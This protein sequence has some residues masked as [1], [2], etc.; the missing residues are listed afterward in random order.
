MRG[1]VTCHYS[2]LKWCET[3]KV[4]GVRPWWWSASCRKEF[5]HYGGYVVGKACRSETRRSGLHHDQLRQSSELP[6]DQSQTNDRSSSFQA[7]DDGQ[8]VERSTNDWIVKVG[9]YLYTIAVKQTPRRRMATDA[10]REFGR[11][12]IAYKGYSNRRIKKSYGYRETPPPNTH[13]N[14]ANPIFTEPL[15]QRWQGQQQ[16]R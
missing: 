8:A 15:K 3:S 11:G 13:T 2:P 1:W 10:T 14:N 7:P 12:K 9:R 5:E 6:I 16:A 4:E